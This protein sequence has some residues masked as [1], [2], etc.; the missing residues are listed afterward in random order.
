MLFDSQSS[1]SSLDHINIKTYSPGGTEIVTRVAVE[2]LER[3]DVSIHKL[4]ARALLGDLE[5]GKS[6]IQLD[7]NRPTRHSSE[8]ALV[9]AEGEDLGRKWSLVSKWTSFYAIEEPY[10][11]EGN[12]PDPFMDF[13]DARIHEAAGGI[14]LLQ[15]RGVPGQRVDGPIQRLADMGPA[16]DVEESDEDDGTPSDADTADLGHDS[17]SDSDNEDG[18]DDG[19]GAGGNLGNG[20]NG[21]PQEPDRDNTGPDGDGA[22]REEDP[23]NRPHG[24]PPPGVARSFAAD[25]H[26]PNT[27]ETGNPACELDAVTHQVSYDSPRS[28]VYEYPQL[29]S[30]GRL[31]A[32]PPATRD[33]KIPTHYPSHSSRLQT[34]RYSSLRSSRY[35]SRSTEK[36][37]DNGTTPDRVADE[38]YGTQMAGSEAYLRGSR[39]TRRSPAHSTTDRYVPSPPIGLSSRSAPLTAFNPVSEPL[40]APSPVPPIVRSSIS[41]LHEHGRMSYHFSS[42]MGTYQ[43]DCTGIETSST[44]NRGATTPQEDTTSII[45]APSFNL[46]ASRALISNQSSAPRSAQE[47]RGKQVI[48]RLLAFQQFDGAF[49]F[50]ASLNPLKDILGDE[51]VSVVIGIRNQLAASI[52]NRQFL[53]STVGMMVLFELK[54]QFCRD[55]WVMV[56]AK[57]ETFVSREF[58]NKLAAK[59]ATFQF[60]RERIQN[61]QVPMPTGMPKASADGGISSFAT[62]PSRPAPAYDLNVAISQGGT[63][64][65][66]DTAPVDD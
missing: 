43:D 32:D 4:G 6:W 37:S 36:L 26:I 8:E 24:G 15:P 61:L 44:F 20:R 35:R 66:L 64:V 53:A 48:R 39:L 50:G 3:N 63:R 38:Y 54:L 52:I 56:A 22:R 47:R 1:L 51:F 29:E 30:R 65:A 59:D 41:S 28:S 13:G 5:R 11:A 55:L 21:P 27:G 49:D 31:L 42:S 2:A 16:Q 34:S 57:A 7:P 12:V 14:G 60:A 46:P 18:G 23:Q 25:V 33:Q 62:I 19:G 9:R 45:S 10:D 58:G 17:D 40:A